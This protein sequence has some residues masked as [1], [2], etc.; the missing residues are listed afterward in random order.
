M[1]LHWPEVERLP[2]AGALHREVTR[3]P[4]PVDES[5]PQKQQEIVKVRDLLIGVL[6]HFKQPEQVYEWRRANGRISRLFIVLEWGECSCPDT[7]LA[8][9]RANGFFYLRPPCNPV[10][11]IVR[12]KRRGP[13][14]LVVAVR[15][16]LKRESV[17]GDRLD[18]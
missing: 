18:I 2:C 15:Q 16:A 10:P 9:E 7:I 12:T 6:G 14:P 3:Y 4:W 11:P 13:P 5:S 17:S 1:W 8:W